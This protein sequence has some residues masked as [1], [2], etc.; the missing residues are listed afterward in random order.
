M[1]VGGLIRQQRDQWSEKDFERKLHEGIGRRT[2]WARGSWWKSEVSG[3]VLRRMR[4]FELIRYFLFQ[5]SGADVGAL[6]P[7]V[8]R[9]NCAEVCLGAPLKNARWSFA[10]LLCRAKH[11]F[12]LE[13]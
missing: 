2:G 8:E 7:I 4:V 5:W 9:I 13:V 10:W 1:H 12:F 3:E 11:A 6:Q